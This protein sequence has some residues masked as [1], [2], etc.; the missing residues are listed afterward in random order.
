[1]RL[2]QD[3]II[4]HHFFLRTDKSDYVNYKILFMHDEELFRLVIFKGLILATFLILSFSANQL[5]GV[6][7]FKIYHFKKVFECYFEQY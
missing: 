3:L 5:Y 7:E 6:Y 2:V 4:L 1:M